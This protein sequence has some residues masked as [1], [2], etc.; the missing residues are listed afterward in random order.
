ME[1]AKFPVESFTRIEPAEPIRPGG[2][3]R[4]LAGILALI[5]TCSGGG[6]GYQ[7]FQF[8]GWI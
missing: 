7:S 5:A 4:I 6:G 2:A 3:I 1:D 8:G